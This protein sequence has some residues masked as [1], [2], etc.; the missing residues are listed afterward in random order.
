SKSDVVS[1]RA[2]SN[3]CLRLFETVITTMAGIS[4]DSSRVT[5]LR[6]PQLGDF[7]ATMAKKGVSYAH[8][9]GPV[10]AVGRVEEMM[11]A[12]AAYRG[13]QPSSRRIFSGLAISVGGSPRR[14]GDSRKGTSLPV[15]RRVAAMTSRIL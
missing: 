14:R 12:R 10:W 13:S 4:A 11:S 15:T 6:N 7:L 9:E 3:C 2:P 5:V 1:A 8:L